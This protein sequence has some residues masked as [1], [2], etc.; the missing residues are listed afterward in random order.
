MLC[1]LLL[2]LLLILLL[3]PLLEQSIAITTVSLLI[4]P[5]PV[6]LVLFDILKL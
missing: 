1:G 4:I 3:L 2:L 5:W 6:D